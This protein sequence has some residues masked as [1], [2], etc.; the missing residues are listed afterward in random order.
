MGRTTKQL[1]SSFSATF[2][3]PPTLEDHMG[4]LKGALEAREAS[5]E[6]AA[7]RCTCGHPSSLPSSDQ[8]TTGLRLR[9]LALAYDRTQRDVARD[10]GIAHETLSRILSGAQRGSPEILAKIEAAITRSGVTR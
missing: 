6:D 8:A 1:R 2:V 4:S 3:T 10:A 9:L 5:I 7:F